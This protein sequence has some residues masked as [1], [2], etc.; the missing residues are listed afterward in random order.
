MD[1]R[2][3]AISSRRVDPDPS[4]TSALGRHH[5]LP[6]AVADLVDNSIDAGARHVLVRILREQGRAVGLLVVDD[7]RGMDSERVDEAMAYARRREYGSADLG[8]FGIGLKAA[9]LSQ[10]ETLYAWSRA[11]GVPAVGRGLDRA[12]LDSG[13]IVRTFS[14]DDAAARL[15]EVEAGFDL[16]TGTVIEWRDVTAFFRSPDAAEQ[17]DWLERTL[18]DLRVHLGVVLHRIL[19]RGAVSVVIDV[20]EEDYPEYGPGAPRAVEPL[21]PFGYHRTG[22][23]AYPQDL[24]LDLA[25]GTA[26]AGLHVWP[27]E[28]RADAAFALG[29]RSPLETQ[30]LYVYR[31][32]RLLQVGGWNG[33]VTASRDLAF[34]RVALDLDSALATHVSINP[35]KAD[36]RFDAVLTEAWHACRTGAGT[37]FQDYLEAARGGAR[38]ARRRRPRPVEVVEPGRGFAAGVV[39][40]FDENAA[41]TAGEEPLDL[42]WRSLRRDE[43]FRLDREARTIW[44]NSRY[45]AALGGSRGLR[46]DDAQ[47]VKALLHVLI[48]PHL[49]GSMTGPRE[50]RVA[51]AYQAILLAAVK[52]QQ[53][54]SENGARIDG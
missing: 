24:V 13:P 4:I 37:T 52:E 26:T 6:T 40:A 54:Q 12:T 17:R 9:S 30:G 36:V 41:F 53:H 39:D 14:T 48:G 10:A 2:P 15:A 31:R 3:T 16:D 42:R 8:H 38:D 47:V 35:E 32:D 50:K 22:H 45:R 29:H 51:A 28:G 18:E 43:V 19:A 25:A 21:D 46:N 34:A 33:V 49:T 7:G 23:P 5:S 1:R 44:L 20:L 11:W 27:A